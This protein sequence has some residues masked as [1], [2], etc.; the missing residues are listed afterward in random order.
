MAVIDEYDPPL[1]L[2]DWLNVLDAA[3]ESFVEDVV[4]G[5]YE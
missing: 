2:E 4:D 1:E 5:D 3:V